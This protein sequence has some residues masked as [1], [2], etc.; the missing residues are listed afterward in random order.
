MANNARIPDINTLIQAGIDPRT[1]LP[2][3]MTAGEECALQ[4]NIKRLLRIVDEQDAV[5][6]Y[7]WYNLPS[8]LDGHLIERILYYKG[9]AMFF[10]IDTVDQ[11]FFLPYALEG[12]IDVYGR[13]TGVKP[14][15]F[16]GV[17]AAQKPDKSAP[18]YWL[19]TLT[20]KPVYD[21]KL[22]ELKMENLKDSCVLL[23]D[24]SKQLSETVISRQ[25]L[26]E[27]LLNV[28]ADCVP[29]MRT[30]MLNSTGVMGMR[31]NSQDEQSNVDAASRSINKA[32]L[33]GKKYIP[34]VGNVDF[35]EM[36]GGTVGKS[37]EFLEAMQSLDNL[38][39]SMY[40]LDNGGLF[41][42]KSHML[43]AEQEMNGGQ[44]GLVY[45]D[46]LIIRQKF[47]DIVN[48]IWGLGI[49]C[50]PS[51]T[52]LG[53]D[54]NGDMATTDEVDQSGTMEGEQPEM[55]GIE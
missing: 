22:D 41:Q 42:K 37:E 12:T 4:E 34:I 17:N 28:M 35:Q 19:T 11:F 50:E 6:R 2:I 3:R 13:F 47:C 29:F 40:G 1:G 32:A 55:G 30:A 9:Q 53:Q 5:N 48:S 43:Q 10:Y 52:V 15:P 23:H 26:Q 39:L 20:R 54:M 46:G 24:Y 14:L 31:V 18:D 33:S 27:P 21:I 36:T 38:R 8:G 51:E 16:N 25:I 49:S 45:N 7:T 44:T